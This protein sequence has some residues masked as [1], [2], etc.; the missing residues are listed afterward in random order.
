MRNF[1]SLL[2]VKHNVLYSKQIFFFLKGA[3][4]VKLGKETMES[5]WSRGLLKVLAETVPSTPSSCPAPSCHTD[6]VLSYTYTHT[7]TQPRST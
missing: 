7:H 4:L 6:D 5:S 1:L 3:A 2:V